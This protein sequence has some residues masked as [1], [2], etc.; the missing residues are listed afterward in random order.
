MV[1]VNVVWLHLRKVE[2]LR[3]EDRSWSCNSN[4]PN[5]ALSWDL[6]MLHCPKSN[7]SSSS[8]KPSFAVNGNSSVVWPLKVLLYN[9]EKVSDNLVWR[10]GSVN[11][12]KIIVSNTSVLEVLLIILFFVKSDDSRYVDALKDISILVW[13]V[14]ISLALVSVL[15]WS[16]ECYELAWN[17]PVEVSVLN[18]L[19]V[20][21]LLNVKGPEVIPPESYGIL[22]SLQ[23]VEQGTVVEAVALGGISVVLEQA[24]VWLELLI[25][26]LS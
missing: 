24:V 5:K 6:E 18:S 17:N 15:D 23:A 2:L 10:S 25:C 8:S 21:V 13:V 20:L 22:Q 7:E 16:H 26:S 4:P 11:K 1:S 19:I 3:A 12:E 14:A 9:V